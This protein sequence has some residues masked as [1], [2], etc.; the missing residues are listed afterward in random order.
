MKKSQN[1]HY[2]IWDT[3]GWYHQPLW[4]TITKIFSVVLDGLLT[5][6]HYMSQ[7]NKLQVITKIIGYNKL[8][9]LS[10]DLLVGWQEGHPACKKLSSYSGDS[11]LTRATCK[12]ISVC[13]FKR[14]SYVTTI[15]S[16]I[17]YCSK[18][19]TVSHSGSSLASCP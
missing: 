14:V 16:V 15:A 1:E 18:T 5:M 6:T 19:R 8:I 17:F 10:S 4:V 12:M 11:D 3:A 13:L 9:L 7:T 2:I